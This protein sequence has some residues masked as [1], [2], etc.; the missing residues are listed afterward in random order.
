M[1]VAPERTPA[2]DQPRLVVS[3]VGTSLLTAHAGEHRSRLQVDLANERELERADELLV[4][5]IAAL[6]EATLA[7]GDIKAIRKKSAELNGIYALYDNQIAR[8]ARDTHFLIT[9]D[10]V[11]GRRAGDLVAAHLKPHAAVSQVFAPPYLTAAGTEG[12]ETGS[13]ELIHWCAEHIPGYPRHHVIFNLVG[14][15]KALQGYLNTIGMFYADE[16]V[17][18]FE[19]DNANLIRIPRLPIQIDLETLKPF[20]VQLA[21][22]A[23]GETMVSVAELDGLSHALYDYNKDGE[24]IFSRWGSLIWSQV[25]DEL[26]SGLPLAFP[27]FS[28]APSFLK[29][30]ERISTHDRP[31]YQETLAKAAR[32]FGEGNGDLVTLRADG[33]L[34]YENYAQKGGIGHFRVTQALRISCIVENGTL[35]LRHVGAHDYVNNNP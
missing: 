6:A 4:N 10:T 35:V 17:Y 8:S 33:G 23:E 22:M 19:G 24:A 5:T 21:M 27:R 16:I 31:K 29:D 3:T 28:Y 9:T 12:F 18:L 15:F 14:G 13:K 7:G 25:G 1:R 26:L 32:L 30:W 2:F 34:K 11:L 20:A